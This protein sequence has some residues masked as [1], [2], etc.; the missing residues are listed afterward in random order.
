MNFVFQIWPLLIYLWFWP[1][2]GTVFSN[3]SYLKHVGL[4]KHNN[5]WIWYK[6][7][8]VWNLC[9]LHLTSMDNKY[10]MEDVVKSGYTLCQNNCAMSPCFCLDKV[11]QTIPPTSFVFFPVDIVGW[12]WR[13][14]G[15]EGREFG[16]KWSALC[17]EGL[18]RSRTHLYSEKFLQES[19]TIFTCPHLHS[20]AKPY[21]FVDKPHAL[22]NCAGDAPW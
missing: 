15:G 2:T 10:S 6:Y 22:M 5:V 21:L 18:E 11:F 7:N 20:L 4:K 14:K 1:M 3:F 17:V 13:I 12:D 19:G 9:V 16:W 8:I